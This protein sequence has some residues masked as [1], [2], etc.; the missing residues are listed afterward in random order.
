MCVSVFAADVQQLSGIKEEVLHEWSCQ[1]HQ[2]D[3]ELL[4]IKKEEEEVWTSQEGEQLHGQEE[5]DISRFSFT[6]APVKTEDDEEKPQFSPVLQVKTEENRET[7]P[8]TSSSAEQME[9]ETDGEDCGGP[10]P[11]RNPDPNTDEEDSDCSDTDDDDDWNEQSSGSGSED[12]V[13]DPELRETRAVQSGSVDVNVQ[14]KSTKKSFSCSECEKQFVYKQSL[15][16][17]MARHSGKPS[18]SST[19]DKK[20]LKKNADPQTSVP[21]GKN[22]CD[23]C[24]Q[25]V[26]CRSRLEIHMRV[27]TGERP[28]TCDECGK[29]FSQKDGLKCHMNSHSGERPFQCD[30]CCKSFGLQGILKQHMKIHSGEKPY[31][32]KRC[33]RRFQLK[34]DL[35]IHMIN[36]SGVKPFGCG[37]CGARF[38]RKGSLMRHTRLHTG[39]KPFACHQCDKRFY[40]KFHLDR[41]TPVHSGRRKVSTEKRRFRCDDCGKDFLQSK[42]L[43]AHMAIHTGEKPFNCDLCNATFSRRGTLKRHGRLVHSK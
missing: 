15:Q 17:H 29:T 22:R 25:T 14:C 28:F 16:R 36:H 18:S 7:E 9:I 21:A 30:V 13:G 5:T 34:G 39:E 2:E 8:L 40:R 24:G 42:H 4:H 31:A 20:R 6:A 32:C 41:H 11:D 27:H 23:E 26:S 37:E 43:K 33:D 35:K 38:S 19:A 10:E 3:P 1:L 12:E